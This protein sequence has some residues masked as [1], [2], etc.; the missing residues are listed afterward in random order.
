MLAAST[1]V[2]LSAMH[3]QH[4]SLGAT[5]TEDGGWRRPAVYSTVEEEVDRLRTA[6]GI[7]DISP[8]GKL[9]LLGDGVDA[10]VGEAFVDA[11]GIE[12]GRCTFLQES[13]HTDSPTVLVAR[14]AVDEMIAFTEP[15]ERDAVHESLAGH[16]GPTAQVVDMTSSFSGVAIVGPA[17]N[18]VLSAVSDLDASPRSFPNMGC[19]Q[20]EVAEIHGIFVRVDVGDVPS[21]RLYF[22]REYGA[23]LW[24]ALLDAGREYDAAPVGIEALGELGR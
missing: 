17:A 9:S 7:T 5:M 10:L 14:L 19:A 23:Y 12:I 20:G 1:P 16:G 22:G 15:A 13:G 3:D 4:Q 21:F 11:A 6:A 24:E 2:A 18:L 8:D